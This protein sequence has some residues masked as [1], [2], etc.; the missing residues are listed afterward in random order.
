MMLRLAGREIYSVFGGKARV[1]HLRQHKTTA[2][3]GKDDENNDNEDT[4]NE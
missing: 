1:T 3:D 4:M 2:A